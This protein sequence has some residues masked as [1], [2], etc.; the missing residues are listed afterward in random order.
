MSGDIHDEFTIK[1]GVPEQE[2]NASTLIHSLIDITTIIQEV[3]RELGSGEPLDVKIKA[4]KPGSFL[5]DLHLL[6]FYESIKGLLTVENFK[7]TKELITAVSSLIS[8]RKVFKKDEPPKPSQA[9]G[10]VTIEN[11]DGSTLTIDNRVFNLYLNNATIQEALNNNFETLDKDPTVRDF[12]ILDEKSEKLVSVKREEFPEMTTSRSLLPGE[13]RLAL[14]E[15]LKPDT[16]RAQLYIVRPSFDKKLKWTFIYKE[17][18]I[19][20]PI[21]DEEFE[22]RVRRGDEGFF[23]GDILDVI[24]QINKGLEESAQV[25]YNKSYKV[26]KVIKHIKRNEQID[27]FTERH[28]LATGYRAQ[29][30]PKTDDEKN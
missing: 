20:A 1:Y 27:L 2:I 13:S 23:A 22:S 7:T 19:S 30:P 21:A 29:L 4:L 8:L 5:V 18:K 25:A 11:I 12:E 16:V 3:N 10:N 24:L 28:P 15:Q 14:S 17:I 26:L 9:G 6:G